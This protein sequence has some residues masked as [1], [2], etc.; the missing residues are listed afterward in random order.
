MEN[1]M[2]IISVAK[3]ISLNSWSLVFCHISRYLTPIC[4][5]QECD[6][7]LEAVRAHF[8][9]VR[10]SQLCQCKPLF[11]DCW[12][13]CW[14]QMPF[15]WFSALHLLLIKHAGELLRSSTSNQVLINLGAALSRV[16]FD[17]ECTSRVLNFINLLLDKTI[18]VIYHCRHHKLA[19]SSLY[20]LPYPNSPIT[21]LLT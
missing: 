13:D 11:S 3:C 15:T 10:A 5:S 2:S 20:G 18:Q 7:L 14:S 8:S 6:C 17:P 9:V 12:Q 1:L 16:S 21:L 19:I 4:V